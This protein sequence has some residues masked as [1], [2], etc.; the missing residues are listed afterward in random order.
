MVVVGA[1]FLSWSKELCCEM[2]VLGSLLK[3][4]KY[5][6]PTCAFSNTNTEENYLPPPY[7]IFFRIF[8][9]TTFKKFSFLFFFKKQVCKR[10]LA[11][12]FTFSN[13]YLFFI[14]KIFIF[15]LFYFTI[16]Y[17]FCHTLTRIRHGCTWV[18]NHEPPPLEFLKSDF[19]LNLSKFLYSLAFSLLC[20]VLNC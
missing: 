3:G 16:L 17:W 20:E 12:F 13:F 14:K 11:I 4:L 9:D 6:F 19:N 7:I 15:T 5:F 1:S 8:R 10:F 2:E 18:P